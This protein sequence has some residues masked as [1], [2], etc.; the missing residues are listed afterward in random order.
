MGKTSFRRPGHQNCECLAQCSG[1][2]RHAHSVGYRPARSSSDLSTMPV[3]TWAKHLFGG[4]VTR[5]ANAWHSVAGSTDM[6][7]VWA[8][9]ECAIGVPSQRCRWPHGQNIFSA[10]RSPELRMLGTV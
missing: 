10:A 3:A 1:Q 8:N 5:T 9:A 2:H 4:P 6:L 7:T